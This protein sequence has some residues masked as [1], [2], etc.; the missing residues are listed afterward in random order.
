LLTGFSILN[1]VGTGEDAVL[2]VTVIIALS[3][4]SGLSLLLLVVV[5][6]S[7][8]VVTLATLDVLKS[9]SETIFDCHDL[10]SS[11]IEEVVD[12]SLHL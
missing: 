8:L 3:G 1:D 9:L 4:S 10:G 12:L 7:A 11:L 2:V 5:L 6:G